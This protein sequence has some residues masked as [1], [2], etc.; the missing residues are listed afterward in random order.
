M[1]Y[2]ISFYK[3]SA[4]V[5]VKAPVFSFEQLINVGN[6]LDPEMKS[7][8]EVLEIARTHEEALCKELLVAG[9]SIEKQSGIFIFVFNINKCEIADVAK[10]FSDLA[11]I[12][13]V[14]KGTA[15]TLKNYEIDAIVSDKIHESPGNTL[16]F[17]KNRK[18]NYVISISSKNRISSRD[19]AEIRRKTVEC[20]ICC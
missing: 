5:A 19:S 14:T 6:H 3:K 11:F 9:Y 1:G 18:V 8:G 16:G 13:Y 17:I 2:G 7:T 12:I 20:N 15:Q 10:K 4:Y